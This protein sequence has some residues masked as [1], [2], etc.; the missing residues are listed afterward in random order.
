MES[1]TIWYDLYVPTKIRFLTLS[2]DIVH[3]W[4]VATGYA[5]KKGWAKDAACKEYLYSA[6]FLVDET[7]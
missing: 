2:F 5:E 6:G 3:E 4:E 7:S 1:D